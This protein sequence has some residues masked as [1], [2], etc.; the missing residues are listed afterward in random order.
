MRDR[1][2]RSLSGPTRAAIPRPPTPKC[3]GPVGWMLLSCH[4]IRRNR[5]PKS[6][7]RCGI[8]SR[9]QGST[10]VVAQ[11]GSR[12]TMERTLSRVALPS[13]SRRTSVVLLTAIPRRIGLFH[14]ELSRCKARKTGTKFPIGT[15]RAPKEGYHDRRRAA[16]EHSLPSSSSTAESYPSRPTPS[17]PRAPV[18]RCILVHLCGFKIFVS[19]FIR[20]TKLLVS[21]IL[22]GTTHVGLVVSCV[23]ENVVG[24]P[25]FLDQGYV[26]RRKCLE[27]LLLRGSVGGDHFEARG[28]EKI[29]FALRL[30]AGAAHCQA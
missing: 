1:I 28:D 26:V 20:Q 5:S 30:R 8:C 17:A 25:V 24:L 16:E 3:A 4:S 29:L 11:T 19:Q 14:R 10:T 27:F 7:S 6:A 22:C 15:A 12:P 2:R 21:L 23:R 18:H 9:C 13:G